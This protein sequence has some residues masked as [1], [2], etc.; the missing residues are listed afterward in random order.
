MAT[1]KR[2]KQTAY[3]YCDTY[4][5]AV[6]YTGDNIQEICAL[7][8]MMEWRLNTQP[9]LSWVEVHSTNGK[10]CVWATVRPGDLIMY[11]TYKC[12]GGGEFMSPAI[13]RRG[14]YANFTECEDEDSI[15]SSTTTSSVVPSIEYMREQMQKTQEDP[16]RKFALKYN[17]SEKLCRTVVKKCRQHYAADD[18]GRGTMLDLLTTAFEKEQEICIDDEAFVK[19]NFLLDKW[20]E[21]Y[22]TEKIMPIGYDYQENSKLKL[23]DD[24]KVY[25]Q[26]TLRDYFKVD[27]LLREHVID[28]IPDMVI[29]N[30]CNQKGICETEFGVVKF[31]GD[32]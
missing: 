1:L 14:Y 20:V 21:K 24:M 22:G 17:I 31:N 12:D 4:C 13:E 2:Y 6:K 3:S 7:F 28:Y 11:L 26:D 5:K 23:L 15:W 10:T 25:R 16:I 9:D 32:L 27:V 30:Y 8:P 29:Q 18:V 19:F